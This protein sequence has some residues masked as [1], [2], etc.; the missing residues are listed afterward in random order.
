MAIPGCLQK[1]GLSAKG[2]A[3]AEKTDSGKKST[4]AI[5]I[6]TQ[7]QHTGKKKQVENKTDTGQRRMWRT[8]RHLEV[9]MKESPNRRGDL[10]PNN[11]FYDT[12]ANKN[13]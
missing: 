3:S 11:Q 8:L 5:K 10:P 2:T 9:P 6:R 7:G 13:N 1:R 4:G 12:R